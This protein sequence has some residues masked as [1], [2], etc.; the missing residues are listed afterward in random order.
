MQNLMNKT[1]LDE[2]ANIDTTGDHHL[3]VDKGSTSDVVFGGLFN[4]W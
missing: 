4:R 3:C 2:Q 1:E